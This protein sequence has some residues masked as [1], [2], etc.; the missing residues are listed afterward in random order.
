L[1]KLSVPKKYEDIAHHFTREL[2]IDQKT[3]FEKGK[4]KRITKEGKINILKEKQTREKV[5]TNK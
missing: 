2:I 1:F 5:E 4:G 3:F